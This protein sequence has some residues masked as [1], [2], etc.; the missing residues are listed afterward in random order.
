ME[1]ITKEQIENLAKLARVGLTEEE[2]VSL[3]SD[4][5]SIL[6]YVKQL[7]EV[8]ISGLEATSQVTGLKNITRVDEIKASTISR[9]DLLCNAS[10]TEDGFIKVKSVL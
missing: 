10:E 6:E 4:M 2:K 1:K 9:V 5:N 8:E 7:D 3:S